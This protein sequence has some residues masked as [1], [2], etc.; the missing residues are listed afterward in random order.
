MTTSRFA[1]F[2][3]VA[4]AWFAAATAASAQSPVLQECVDRQAPSVRQILSD[5]AGSFARLPTR[6]N[7]AWLAAGGAAAL[8]AHPADDPLARRLPASGGV[9]DVFGSGGVLGG[10]AVQ[11]AT[12]I[13]VYA[14]GRA[15]KS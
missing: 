14:V 9:D 2:T 1:Q 11:F 5:T 4:L 12:A 10:A 13:G 15:S 3:L 7:A 6:T 8:A